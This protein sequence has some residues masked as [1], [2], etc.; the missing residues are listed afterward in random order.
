MDMNRNVLWQ[1]PSRVSSNEQQRMRTF[2][3]DDSWREAAYS[4]TADLFGYEHKTDN[5]TVA[6]AYCQRLQTVAGFAYV[7]EPLPMRNSRGAVVYYLLFAAANRV[8]VGIVRDI[9]R[10]YRRKAAGRA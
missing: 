2:W 10:K 4:T 7:A 6:K 8:A 9:F 1:D 3:G 5:P